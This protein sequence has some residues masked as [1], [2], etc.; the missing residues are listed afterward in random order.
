MIGYVIPEG[1]HLGLKVV[2]PGGKPEYLLA[3]EEF[4]GWN[5]VPGGETEAFDWYPSLVCGGGLH[6]WAWAQG[7]L[8]VSA[9]WGRSDVLWLAVEYEASSAVDLG[10]KVKVPKCKTLAV[11]SDRKEIVSFI[12]L[13][14]PPE[15]QGLFF[16]EE[17]IV[18][19]GDVE[20]GDGG[21]AISLSGVAKARAGFAGRAEV[22]SGSA[23][24]GNRGTAIVQGNGIAIARDKGYAKAGDNGI[25]IVGA[26]GLAEVGDGGSAQAGPNGKAKAGNR[27]RARIVGGGGT[28]EVGANGAA[29]AG[30]GSRICFQ[31]LEFFVGQEGIEPDTFYELGDSLGPGVYVLN[32]IIEAEV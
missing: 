15:K 6:L 20:V 26:A 22:A 29:A 1:K 9:I 8:S 23:H 24:A 25:A 31:G 2:F 5:L 30:V 14:T 32:A 28:A 17:R 19:E 13:H 10:G 3:P 4:K 18:E 7:D 27:G 11:S 21:T 12:K 16:F